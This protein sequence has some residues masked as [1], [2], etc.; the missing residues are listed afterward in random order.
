MGSPVVPKTNMKTLASALTNAQNLDLKYIGDYFNSGTYQDFPFLVF[1]NS[2][3]DTTCGGGFIRN[4]I[5]GKSG[6]RPDNENGLYRVPII[7]EHLRYYTE[8]GILNDRYVTHKQLNDARWNVVQS[9]LGNY[10]DEGENTLGYANTVGKLELPEI[11]DNQKLEA[12]NKIFFI[13]AS[14]TP[15]SDVDINVI[16]TTAMTQVF[17]KLFT[18][19]GELMTE[20]SQGIQKLVQAKVI[21]DFTRPDG[22]PDDLKQINTFLKWCFD[23]NMYTRELSFLYEDIDGVEIKDFDKFEKF[24]VLKNPTT[25]KTFWASYWRIEQSMTPGEE[26]N[27]LIKKLQEL[28]TE[29]DT[30]RE[31]DAKPSIIT[32]LEGN[33]IRKTADDVYYTNSAFKRDAIGIDAKEMSDLELIEA[34]LENAGFILEYIDHAKHTACKQG[35]DVAKKY[36]KYVARCYTSAAAVLGGEYKDLAV[37]YVEI[38]THR[39]A[40]NFDVKLVEALPGGIFTIEKLNSKNYGENNLVFLGFVKELHDDVVGIITN[41]IDAI[42]VHVL[43]TEFVPTSEPDSVSKVLDFEKK[44]EQEGGSSHSGNVWGIALGFLVVAASALVPR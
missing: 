21:R 5:I 39:G 36:I 44:P 14:T 40:D 22:E 33:E 28:N 13:K 41:F 35:V 2:F 24:T 11:D 32:R 6:F 18:G 37:K 9:M 27:T 15:S 1:D 29:L 43:K 17:D 20:Y 26:K 25:H 30:I 42:D 4:N 16:S 3:D 7:W 31:K 8:A 38:E 10:V 19:L 23:A 12:S 34:F